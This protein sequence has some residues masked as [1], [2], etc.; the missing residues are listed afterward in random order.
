MRFFAILLSIFTF[1]IVAAQSV[2]TYSQL[3]SFESGITDE[4][5]DL[6]YI[7]SSIVLLSGN[8]CDYDTVF[9]SCSYVSSFSP[10]GQHIQSRLYPSLF[11]EGSNRLASMGDT[12]ILIG[13]P[14]GL[15]QGRPT[16]IHLIDSH[17]QDI[18]TYD[19]SSPSNN[20]TVN[21]NGMICN[22]NTVYLY[23]N[24]VSDGRSQVL[25]QSVDK[26]LLTTNWDRKYRRGITSNNCDDL[27]FTSDGNLVYIN[28]YFDNQGAGG[29][30]GSQIVK[31]L[32][33]GEKLDSF[34]FEGPAGKPTSMYVSENGSYYYFSAVN[35]ED[36]WASDNGWINKLS[37]NMEEVEW[38]TPLPSEPFSNNWKYNALDFIEA[39]NG[40]V[41]VCGEATGSGWH[42][43]DSHNGFIAR[44][45][46]GGELKWTKIYR[47]PNVDA[48]PVDEFGLYRQGKLNKVIES[49]TG[50]IIACGHARYSPF[51]FSAI[52]DLELSSRL[53]LLAVDANGCL[54]GEEC[55]DV[56]VLDGAN[57]ALPVFDIGTRWT[58][59]VET[60]SGGPAKSVSFET[61]EIVDTAAVGGQ[62][63]FAV[64]E[65]S[66]GNLQYLR[67]EGSRVYFWD[68]ELEIYLLNYDFSV[69]SQYGAQWTS[70]CSSGGGI[71]MIEVDSVTQET[72]MGDTLPVQHLRIENNGTIEGDLLT[73]VY[74]GIGQQSGGLRL[75]LGNGLC[76]PVREVT[77]LRCFEND[78]LQ[79]NFVGYSCDSTFVITSTS[80][81]TQK[82]IN[83]FPNP[84]S[85]LI[86]IEG[87]PPSAAYEL[88]AVDGQLV[89]SGVVSGGQLFIKRPGIYWLKV[90]VD[91]HWQVVKVAVL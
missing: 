45:S 12:I 10:S 21:C 54:A 72:V 80:E 38:H 53:W 65:G 77:Q 11:P 91:Q 30:Y 59:E 9:R 82:E 39:A 50:Q 79:Y 88:Y 13:H 60:A 76:D 51:Q 70:Q 33:T 28:S 42:P 67:Q 64:E 83:L 8:F 40:D 73:N 62:I 87:A 37:P 69:S 44:I 52:Q 41:I 61:Y 17:F 55:Q 71:A 2:D 56:I 23:G 49:P 14:H 74:A 48:L 16:R 81:V 4:Y 68:T 7:D 89:Q 22:D 66:T 31:L 90:S 35:P 27:Q 75:P 43:D 3:H 86:N 20:E 63:A 34:E 25:I 84:S 78:S 58:Y 26:S 18:Q 46:P 24:T 85:G 19:V 1:S 57:T 32:P 36:T 15:F 5:T 47:H 29:E 6:E